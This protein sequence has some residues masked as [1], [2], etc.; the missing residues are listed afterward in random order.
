MLPRVP[1]LL[2]ADGDRHI[3][4]GDHALVQQKHVAGD[5]LAG[6]AAL[7]D[8]LPDAAFALGAQAVTPPTNRSLRR[9]VSISFRPF[10]R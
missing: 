2:A 5:G 10:A 8:D 3:D 9:A 1:G 4:V 7:D 6:A